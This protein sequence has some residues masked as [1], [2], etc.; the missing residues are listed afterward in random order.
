MSIALQ[1]RE[2]FAIDCDGRGLNGRAFGR[3]FDSRQVQQATS[4]RTPDVAIWKTR[5]YLI[6]EFR[7]PFDEMSE[8]WQNSFNLSIGG[9]RKWVKKQYGFSISKSTVC[10]VRDKCGVD[11]LELG[12]AKS[13]PKLKSK[14]ELAVLEAFKAL[15]LI[16]EKLKREE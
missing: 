8:Y 2:S 7:N 16:S 4:G 12:A 10:S 9:V 3:G 6:C 13:I 11:K 5:I 15:G 14:K 1:L